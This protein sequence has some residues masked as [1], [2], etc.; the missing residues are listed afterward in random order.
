[1]QGLLLGIAALVLVC[2]SRNNFFLSTLLF[3]FGGMLGQVGY[4]EETGD[5]VM[6][7]GFDLLH[8]G[9][10]TLAV[11]TSLFVV[12]VLL[13]SYRKRP[14]TFNFPG[15]SFAGYKKVFYKMKNHT[16]T[17]MRSSFLGSLGGLM[18]GMSFGFSSLLA[19]ITEK[20]LRKKQKLYRQ[21]DFPSLIASESANNAGVFTQLIPLLFLGIPNH[22]AEPHA[23]GKFRPPFSI[24]K[25]F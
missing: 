10:P 11:L 21:G 16:S 23:L 13:K 6:T 9:I 19:Y 12:P 15:V 8:S 7:L 14:G 18:P 17:L 22:H 24:L 1:M 4:S 20:S 25:I 3:V 5:T 2:V